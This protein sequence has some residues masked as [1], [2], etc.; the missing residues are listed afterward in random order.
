VSAIALT[1]TK[2]DTLTKL[3][4]EQCDLIG[5]TISRSA[6]VR[7]LLRLA[8]RKIEPLEL[9]DE[10]EIELQQGRRWGHDAVKPMP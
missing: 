5:R 6:I 2:A 9:R 8:G 7:A 4:Q 1:Q 10:I 3:E